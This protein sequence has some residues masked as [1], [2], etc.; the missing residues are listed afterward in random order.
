[1]AEGGYD[2]C[3]CVCAHEYAMR[4]LLSFVSFITLLFVNLRDRLVAVSPTLFPVQ[5]QM[6]QSDCTQNQC[7]S[8]RKFVI[9]K[10]YI[11]GS[12][13][14]TTI[15]TVVMWLLR[16]TPTMYSVCM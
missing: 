2:P 1:M 9:Y 12:L 11:I 13:R 6:S 14:L 7:F 3:E 16:F 8:N 4:R 15:S 5:I 10:M